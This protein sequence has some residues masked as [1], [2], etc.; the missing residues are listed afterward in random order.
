MALVG[1]AIPGGGFLQWHLAF[2]TPLHSR[3]ADTALSDLIT[4]LS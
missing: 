4:Q 3:Q 1:F 2:D